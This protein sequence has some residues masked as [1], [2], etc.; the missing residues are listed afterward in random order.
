[1]PA[2]AGLLLARLVGGGSSPFTPLDEPGLVAW[3]DSE[4]AARD[5]G[6]NVVSFTDR[7][8]NGLTAPAASA[9][10]RP[11]TALT[12]AQYGGRPSCG[13]STAAD[14]RVR[15]VALAYGA[16]TVVQVCKVSST[17]TYVWAASDGDYLYS[18]VGFSLFTNTR[19]GFPGGVG[20]SAKNVDAGASWAVSAAPR[21]YLRRMDGT[22]AGD[23]LRVN[24]SPTALTGV[25]TNDPGAIPQS[26]DFS[27]MSYFDDG[28]ASDGTW[29]TTL[30]YD[31]SVS[32]A[33]AAKLEAYFQA[34]YHHY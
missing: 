9:P 4:H 11:T 19:S 34:E 28:S 32:D 14:T 20:P 13:W 21:T 5:G 7:S 24:G 15:A 23:T 29:G 2:G 27:F 10:Q 31:H 17:G 33:V 22:A 1:M 8:G 25:L 12:D 3:W 16:F 26:Q 6:D 30:V 18:S